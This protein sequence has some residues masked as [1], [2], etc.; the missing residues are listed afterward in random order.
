[1]LVK[2][3]NNYIT[4]KE[5]NRL[6]RRRK[7]SRCTWRHLIRF[8]K[9]ARFKTSSSAEIENIIF[10]ILW[11][12]EI[13]AI[14][15]SISENRPLSEKH[16]PKTRVCFAG[17]WWSNGV[18]HAT[19]K[20]LVWN[21]HHGEPASGR[22]DPQEWTSCK[23]SVYLGFECLSGVWLCLKFCYDRSFALRNF[24]ISPDDVFLGRIVFPRTFWPH[25]QI[26]LDFF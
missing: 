6:L 9:P 19:C 18:R 12:V 25:I 2:F 7:K 24:E 11:K 14:S 26:R 23:S 20:A 13:G 1:M 5:V 21:L 15:V 10:F 8:K 3:F 16:P 17:W 22:I 4:E